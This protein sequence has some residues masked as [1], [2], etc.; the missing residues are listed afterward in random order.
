[1]IAALRA[2]GLTAREAESTI[3]IADGASSAD[4]AA[5]LGIGTRTVDKHLQH[6]FAKLGVTTRSQAAARAWESIGAPPGLAEAPRRAQ[7]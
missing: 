5:A 2:A 7:S 4:A 1:M 3:L 6:G